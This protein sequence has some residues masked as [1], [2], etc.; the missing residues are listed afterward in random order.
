MDWETL[1]ERA[2]AYDVT[3]EEVSETLA[4]RRER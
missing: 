3:A 1:F 2:R 4:A